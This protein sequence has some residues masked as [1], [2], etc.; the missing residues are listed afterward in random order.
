MTDERGGAGSEEPKSG[1][2]SFP[3]NAPPPPPPAPGPPSYPSGGSAPSGTS[4]FPGSR[5]TATQG[6]FPPPGSFDKWRPDVP[7]A[8]WATR[9]GGWLI[10]LVVFLVP[11]ILFFVL[12]RH[13]HTLEVHLMARRGTHARRSIST[14]PFLLTGVL[15]VIYGT[16]LCGGARGQTVGMMAVGVRAVRDDAGQGRLGYGRAFARALFEQVL[17]LLDLIFFLLG[18]LWLL[19]MLFPLWDRKRQTLHDKV[20]GSVVLRLRPEG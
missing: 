2:P 13:T 14:L 1:P 8:T 10:D 5:P 6:G 20:A 11:L 9:L 17:R 7:Y 15:Y 18:L 4:S 19:D 12:F 3:G 16:V